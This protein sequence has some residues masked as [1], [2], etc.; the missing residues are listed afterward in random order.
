MKTVWLLRHAKSSWDQPSLAD[1]DRP[2]GQ[3]GLR[4]AP[5]MGRYLAAQRQRPE[6]VLCSSA[7]RTRQTWELVAEQWPSAPACEHDQALYMAD[8]T[9]LLTRLRRL[10]DD[11][12]G[13]LLIGH[14]PGLEDLADTLVG[15]GPAEDLARM[16]KKFPTAALAE[17]TFD[18]ER[19]RSLG[20]G[21]GELRRFVRPKSLPE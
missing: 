10:P 15:R 20:P 1:H 19:W 3:R 16:R 4:D 14:N 5:R 9:D 13:V 21:Q 12:N 18:S 8:E 2:L 11:L 17:I 7:L 6:W